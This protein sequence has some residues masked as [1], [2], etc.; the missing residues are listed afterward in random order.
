[1]PYIQVKLSITPTQQKQAL[2]GAKIRLTAGAIGKGEI[3]LLHP[4]NAKKV[5]TAKNGINLELSPGEI[6][7]TANYHGLVNT[8]GL[9]GAGFFDDVW[10]GLKSVGSWLKNSG[11]GS[12]LADAAV[13][14]IAA[15]TGNPGATMLGRNV[16]KQ[17]T[18]VGIKQKKGKGLYVGKSGNG[19]YV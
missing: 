14:A 19:L 10:S 9:T 17:A 3:V 6:M 12:I 13:P 5:A 16:L 7:H 18:G 11:V 8:N 1:M 4:L 15:Y 2:R